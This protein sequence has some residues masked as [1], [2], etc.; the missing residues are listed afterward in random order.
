MGE[1]LVQI[2]DVQY[3]TLHTWRQKEPLPEGKDMRVQSIESQL[4][5]DDVRLIEIE[6]LGVPL[7]V[8]K[9][10]S[11]YI[12]F[13]RL[14]GMFFLFLA[15][16]VFILAI[17]GF[18]KNPQPDVF[19]FALFLAIFVGTL[20]PGWLLLWIEARAKLEHIIVCEQGLLQT[21]LG[22][23]SKNIET[24]RW[25]NVRRIS[26][27]FFGLGYSIMCRGGQVLTIGLYQDM[28]GLFE[29][30]REQTERR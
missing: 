17:L 8:Y 24:V 14:G 4:S 21:E 1:T 15:A 30:I 11:G 26:P 3:N 10:K 16:A 19:V 22:I 12:R 7:G 28:R 18:M 25:S 27:A 5:S 20:V 13:V 9:V 23:K 6:Q 2:R 29:L